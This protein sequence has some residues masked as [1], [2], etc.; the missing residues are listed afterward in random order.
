M[1]KSQAEDLVKGIARSHGHLG[2]AV[3][4]QMTAFARHEVEEAILAKDKLIGSTVITYVFSSVPMCSR[5][6]TDEHSHSLAKNLYSKDV[7][8]IFELLQNADD[9]LF[10]KARTDS[11][12]P[13]VSF[14]LYHDKIIVDCNEDGFTNLNLKA[15]CN[16]GQSSKHG[17]QGY[18]GEKGI[19]FKS[20][21]KVA[22][23]VWIQSGPF[24]FCFE[25]RRGDSGM[26]MI[27]PLW[28]E[29]TEE[30][31]GPLTRMT[32]YLADDGDPNARAE[33]R[34]NIHE[35]LNDLKP[36]MLLFLNKLRRI[37][38]RLHDDGGNETS[39][40]VLSRV[41]NAGETY[42]AVLYIIKSENGQA[43]GL[44]KKY[45]HVTKVK[46][47]GLAPNENRDYSDEE[48]T[49]RAYSTADVILAFPLTGL[50]V[51]IMRPQELFAFLPI[52]RVGFNVSVQPF[53]MK[54][55]M[56]RY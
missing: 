49:R 7:R 45:Y 16:V 15:I 19:G 25:H 11:E 53:V 5:S 1:S 2:E 12:D 47:T 42:R 31:A 24:S 9:N 22:R 37:E 44:V 8:F 3:Y 54:F 50:Y 32:F 30:L 39:S 27:S 43:P 17:A 38:V 20:V 48:H 56:H 34:R 23:K 26:G 55:D 35:Q 33:Q 21:F 36:E 40:S 10:G 14:C 28:Q 46:A 6:L 51:P 52:R 4:S 29:T 41:E 13:F 18:I